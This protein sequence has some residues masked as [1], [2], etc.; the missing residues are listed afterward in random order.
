MSKKQR[1]VDLCIANGLF[2]C[3]GCRQYAQVMEMYASLNSYMDA[4]FE[5]VVYMTYICSDTEE[6]TV[7][8]IRMIIFASLMEN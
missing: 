5:P 4:M 7:N 3:G 8:Q 1:Y 2:T 6:F